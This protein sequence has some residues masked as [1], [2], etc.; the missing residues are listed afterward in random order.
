MDGKLFSQS[1]GEQ[2]WR[3][4]EEEVADEASSKSGISCFALLFVQQ[5]ERVRARAKG[6]NFVDIFAVP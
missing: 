2:P 6:S 5:G 4:G 3:G 1:R